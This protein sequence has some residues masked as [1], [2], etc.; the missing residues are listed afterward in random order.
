MSEASA[1][2]PHPLISVIVPVYNGES[3]IERCLTA[4]THQ[5]LRRDLYEI[6]V[7]DDGST[8]LTLTNIQ[9]FGDI[10]ITS[11]SNGGPASARNHGVKLS[12]GQVIVFTD[13]DCVP[14]RHF[15]E[16]ICEP[17]FK[18][19]SITG[20]KGCYK[21]GQKEF[22]ARFVQIEY[23][24]KYD[25]LRKSAYIDFVDTYAAAYRKSVF[26]EHGGYDTDFPVACAEDVELSY[27]I[28]AG[29]HRLV[30][31]PEAFVFHTHPNS[32]RKYFAKK[33]KFAYW[34]TFA[35]HKNPEKILKDS[36]T[37]QI[38]KIQALLLPAIAI[39]CILALILRQW[40]EIAVAAIGCYLAL[41]FPFII[42]ALQ[43]DRAIAF[44]CPLFLFCRSLA[45]SAGIIGAILV[46]LRKEIANPIPT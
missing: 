7:V 14:D 29:G 39:L 6:I 45:Q 31:C 33:Y 12:N 35:V 5:T 36:H 43:R 19:A 30:Y 13:A 46:K 28:C 32:I 2:N 15:L 38:M 42:K 17:L 8:D 10:R 11:Q 21:T 20:V 1:V 34:R 3:V 22:V 16:K 44:L 26:G 37:P 23:E 40:T 24:E 25:L 9:K 4:L 18:D 27:R 41:M